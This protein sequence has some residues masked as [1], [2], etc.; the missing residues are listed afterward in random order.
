MTPL[1]RH[2]DKR[3]GSWRS[4]MVSSFIISSGETTREPMPSPGSGQVTNRPLQVCSCRTN[5]SLPSGLRKMAWHP[6]PGS[7]RVMAARYLR[8]DPTW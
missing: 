7:H 5:S 3:S 8:Q 1:W 6:R 4:Y 2:T